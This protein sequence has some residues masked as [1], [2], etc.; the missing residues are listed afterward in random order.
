MLEPE[1]SYTDESKSIV[2]ALPHLNG[3]TPHHYIRSRV[4]QQI[5]APENR[6]VVFPNNS[7]HEQCYN[8]STLSTEQRNQ[9][10]QGKMKPVADKHLATL[11]LLNRGTRLGELFLSGY[12]LGGR[13]ALSMA[14]SGSDRLWVTGLNIAETPSQDGRTAKRLQKDF[15]KSGSPIDLRRSIKEAQIPALSSAMSLGRMAV[16]LAKFGLEGMSEEAKLIQSGM[17]D[18]ANSDLFAVVTHDKIR[19]KVGFIEDSKL[20]DHR[21]IG[22]AT[23]KAIDVVR[24]GGEGFHRHSSA[25]NV[26]L[27]ALMVNDG[28][29]RG[30]RLV[31]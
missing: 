25:D 16:D 22:P 27:H 26:I 29:S 11:E 17:S 8:L 9:L 24:Y 19:V 7:Y 2:L 28:L 21:S 3:W 5:V 31:R 10:A 14:Q 23:K 18:T 30:L 15:L 4:L 12:S 6:V 13:I 20:F 1:V